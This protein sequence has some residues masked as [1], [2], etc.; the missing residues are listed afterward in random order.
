M[1]D[2]T[3]AQDQSAFQKR[4]DNIV[5]KAEPSSLQKHLAEWMRLRRADLRAE[6]AT[7][8]L[9][10]ICKQTQARAVRPPK[11]LLSVLE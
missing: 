10:K 2:Q 4:N 5:M 9:K 3:P 1:S 7:G 11:I 6:V 8:K